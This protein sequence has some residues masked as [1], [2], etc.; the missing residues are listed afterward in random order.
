MTKQSSSHDF[1]GSISLQLTDIDHITFIFLV[2]SINADDTQ[3]TESV[4]GFLPKGHK[5]RR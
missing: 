1:A 3:G 4:R 2:Y 5:W